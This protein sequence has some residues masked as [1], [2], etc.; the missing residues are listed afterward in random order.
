MKPNSK[1]ASY[2]KNRAETY[3]KYHNFL[4]FA[5]A[6][7]VIMLTINIK[8]RDHFFKQLFKFIIILLVISVI[9][10]ANLTVLLYQQ[11]QQFRDDWRTTQLSLQTDASKVLNSPMTDEEKNRMTGDSSRRWW[12]VYLLDTSRIDWIKRTFLSDYH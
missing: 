1:D 11:E 10:A 5:L 9:W 4:K 2:R 3:Y 12:K 7:A 8:K 6:F